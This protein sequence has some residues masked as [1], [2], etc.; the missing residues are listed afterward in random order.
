[1]SDPTKLNV[2]DLV[3]GTSDPS[4]SVYDPNGRKI[5]DGVAFVGSQKDVEELRESMLRSA[6][7]AGGKVAAEP[8]K[9]Q[10]RGR[11]AVKN[12]TI[13]QAPYPTEPSYRPIEETSSGSTWEDLEAVKAPELETVSFENDFGKIR[14][15]VENIIDHELA[16][17]LV[18]SSE[19]DITFEPKV[20]E[21]LQFVRNRHGDRYTVYYPGVIFNWT[22][23]VKKAMILFK[24]ES[25]NE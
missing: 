19:D 23:A 10:K 24:A 15:K 17:M 4:K 22:D 6:T 9:T 8:K 21:T 2:G 3:V 25:Q 13:T 16:L 5:R 18:F 1:M 14:A 20:G 12:K 7:A 11:K